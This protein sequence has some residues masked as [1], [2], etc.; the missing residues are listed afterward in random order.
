MPS[1]PNTTTLSWAPAAFDGF[2]HAQRHAVIV[3]VEADQVRVLLQDRRSR[4]VGDLTVPIAGDA[5]NHGELAA[6]RDRLGEPLGALPGSEDAGL[7]FDHRNL[8]AL[9]TVLQEPLGNAYA[10]VALDIADIVPDARDHRV[11]DVDDGMPA[12]SADFQG[13]LE[14]GIGLRR[15]QRGHR[16]P[17]R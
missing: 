17:A 8:A 5:G 9:R 16:S 11:I 7:A 15:E 1:V 12:A 4:I 6:F 10:V 14:V 2:D 3:G 13:R